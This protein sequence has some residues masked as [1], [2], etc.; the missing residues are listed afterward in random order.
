MLVTGLFINLPMYL[1]NTWY[2]GY[3]P[4]NSN[5]LYDRFGNRAQIAKIVDERGTLDV[6]KYRKAGVYSL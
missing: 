4:F 1:S 2:S 5:K 6:E 3:L